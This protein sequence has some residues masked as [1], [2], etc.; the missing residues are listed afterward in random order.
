VRPTTAEQRAQAMA[1]W[2][3]DPIYLRWQTEMTRPRWGRGSVLAAALALAM[4]GLGWAIGAL[5][6][7][8]L[9]HAGTWWA[10][11]WFALV[12][13]DGQL[14]YPGTPLQFM[15]R[16]PYWLPSAVFATAALA[17]SIAARRRHIQNK[18]IA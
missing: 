17:M 3:S 4:G 16:A 14:R 13:M 8:G 1:K 12:M 5:R 18:R 15:G 2:R 7:S 9:L 10:I 6:P 11:A